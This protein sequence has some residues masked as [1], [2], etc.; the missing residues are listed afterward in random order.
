MAKYAV[1]KVLRQTDVAINTAIV[2]A[3]RNAEH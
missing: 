3:E 2:V 1:R